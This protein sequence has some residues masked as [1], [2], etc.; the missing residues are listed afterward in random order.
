MS[1]PPQ[2]GPAFWPPAVEALLDEACDQF[3]AVCQQAGSCGPL[4]HIEDY[5]AGMV[6]PE[7]MALVRELIPLEIH[8]RRQRGETP[9][10]E[11]YCGRF[12]QLD[13]RWLA[14]AVAASRAPEAESKRLVHTGPWPVAASTPSKHATLLPAAEEA[15]EEVQVPGYE[16]LGELGRGGMGVVYKARQQS[17]KRLVALK[18]ILAGA[19]AAPEQVARFRAEAE[20]VARMQHPHIVQVYEIGEYAGRSFISLE[21]CPGGSL[22]ERF[23]GQPQ[24]GRKAAVL[25][26]T[27]AGAVQHAHAHGIIHRDLK[28]A[29][30]LLAENDTV[31]VSDFGL[32]KQLEPSVAQTQSG[33]IV[34]TPS[35]MAPEQTAGRSKPIG[36]ATDVYALGAILYEA[37]TGRPPFRAA[38]PLETL[39][40][41]RSQEPVAVRQL[42]PS[43]PKDL[44]TICLKCL[45][46]EPAKRYA[47][48]AAFGDDLE[49]FLTGKPI[50][51]RPVGHLERLW[52]WGKRNPMVASLTVVVF[53]LLAA[54]AGV[55]SIGYLREAAA[56]AEAEAAGQEMRRQ[57]YAANL[58]LMQ[59]AWD[60]NRI[61]SLRA[62]LAKTEAY[63]D[64]G[65]EWNYWQRLCHLEIMNLIGHGAEVAAVSWSPDGTRLATASWDQTAKVWDAASGRE[66]RTL[67]GHMSAV[68]AVSW[69]PDGKRL[70]TTS[71]D[72][73]T[74]VWNTAD[75]RELLS[76]KVREGS[77]WSVAWSPDEKL[78]A[79]GG[80]GRIVQ[81]WELA[82]RRELLSVD[83]RE[84]GII[85]LSWSPNSKRLA[86]GKTD[87]TVRVWDGA[88]GRELLTLQGHPGWSVAWSPEGKWLATGG[89][90]GSPKVWEAS[91]GRELFAL[92]GPP[93][94]DR[95]V[96]WSA[97]G[98]QLAIGYADGTAKAWD[99]AGKRERFTFKGHTSWV[100]SV[101]WSPDGK[102]LATGSYDGTVKL[103]DTER[104]RGVLTFQGHTKDIAAVS[105]SPDGKRLASGSADG[106][107]TVWDAADG[108][109]LRTIPG[110]TDEVDSVSWSPDG[111]RLAIGSFD[112]TASVCEVTSGRNLLT[113]SGRRVSWSPDGTRLATVGDDGRATIWDAAENR[114]L[115]RLQG[116]RS[117]ITS[118]AWSPDSKRLA[119]GSA[120]GTAM[121]SDGD[122]GRKLL[123]LKGYTSGIWSISWSADGKRLATGTGEGTAKIWNAADGSEL[124][125][126]KGYWGQVTSLSWSPDGK[127]L[128]TGISEGLTKLWDTASGQELL[129]LPGTTV[130]WSPDGERIAT[131]GNDG[132]VRVWKA[133]S[134]EAVQ[135]WARQER[136]LQETLA[137]NALRGGETQGFIQTWLLLLPLPLAEGEI[138]EQALAR[139]HIPGEAQL[140]PQLGESFKVGGRE[141][142][143][144]EHH[145]PTAMLDFNAILGRI[146]EKSVAYAVCYVQSDRPRND[147]QLQVAGDDQSKV[148]LNGQPVYQSL[149]RPLRSLDTVD[150]VE[151]K[152]G[153]NVLVFKVVNMVD[154]WEGCVRLVDK[155][156]RPVEG[157]RFTLTPEP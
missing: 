16:V 35:Y 74:K 24:P 148:Y 23:Q 124:L 70:A 48:A 110:H 140:R 29:N 49:R 122:R 15:A 154:R 84:G 63:P 83:E 100:N 25:V 127:R 126:L 116:H 134:T 3:E 111:D 101:S 36:P 56:H 112:R 85:S 115:F 55:A 7:R 67:K 119:T 96:A 143:W 114:E 137:R 99:V 133:A 21:Y 81:V 120:G 92:P 34:G 103:W 146:T 27:L 89:H 73:T 98:R 131:G 104:D 94:S 145:A 82:S 105:W 93:A 13:P 2:I 157:V 76:F 139:Q 31:K 1:E 129:T 138:R 50:L 33:V 6:E 123:M 26:Q 121:V 107:A 54:V 61:T 135:E 86:T 71:F 90:D 132:T 97:D 9:R 4:P 141:L 41:V 8:Y 77:G 109:A 51:A 18:M 60:T 125:T 58:S 22:A 65:F 43:V 32:A 152:Q 10:P 130:C 95:S 14:G 156:G 62:L 45:Q 102:R 75:G 42:Q 11:N 87:G 149:G 72:G 39:E 150:K 69:C 113:V 136:T 17:L 147:L 37:L 46:K 78:L 5:L 153:T 64:R 38:T 40:Q 44:E 66:L 144:R 52:R 80:R 20:A 106:T 59:Q 53:F 142:V 68:H 151:L 28:P 128:A 108:R 88:V 118:L 57:W 12:P 155:A 19:H 91:T 79:T 117:A 30:V 47:S